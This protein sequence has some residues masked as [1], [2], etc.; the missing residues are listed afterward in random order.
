MS[1]FNEIAAVR[2]SAYRV[3]AWEAK[4]FNNPAI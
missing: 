4:K 3:A 2:E 1:N